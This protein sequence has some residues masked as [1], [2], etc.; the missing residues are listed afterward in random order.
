MVRRYWY[1]GTIIKKGMVLQAKGKIHPF[2]VAIT[3][4]YTDEEEWQKQVDYWRPHRLKGRPALVDVMHIRFSQ[5]SISR[6]GK[7]VY[8]Y[9]REQLSPLFEYELNLRLQRSV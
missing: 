8:T 1:P 6:D 7:K 2:I 4:E 9:P 5:G 3:D